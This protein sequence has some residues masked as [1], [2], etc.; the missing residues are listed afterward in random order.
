MEDSI[1]QQFRT[2]AVLNDFSFSMFRFSF[3]DSKR[4]CL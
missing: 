1:L 3:Y 4:I 2:G